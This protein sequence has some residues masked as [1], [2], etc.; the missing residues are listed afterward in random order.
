MNAAGFLKFNFAD[1]AKIF[2]FPRID[3]SSEGAK[4]GWLVRLRW[5]ALTMLFLL[6][7]PGFYFGILDRG[8]MVIYIGVV[9][10][11]FVFNFLTQLIF[12][13]P[14]RNFGPL[15]ICLQM[16][17]DLIALTILLGVSG[18]FGNPF[19]GVF[20]LNAALGGVLIRGRLAWPFILLCH[21]LLSLLQ[22]QYGETHLEKQGS[23]LVGYVIVS[24]VILFAVWVVM[25]SLGAS[26]ENHFESLTHARVQSEKQDRL[27]ALG[28]LAAGFSHEFAS[29]LNA[30]RLRLDRLER[31]LREAQVSPAV[32]ENLSEALVSIQAC[33]SVVHSMNSS[34]LDVRDYA[35]KCI[36]MKEFLQDVTDSW[37]ELHPQAHLL[38][39]TSSAVDLVASPVNLAQ[40]IINLLDN[41]LEA[42]AD[43]KILLSLS[44]ESGWVSL[45][46]EDEGPGF[47]PSVLGKKGEPFVTTKA[48]GT[49]LG[50]Y[51][52]DIFVQ[53]M[54]GR[55]LI[56]NKQPG[57]T[58]S[59]TWPLV[60]S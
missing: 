13:G 20:L 53:S 16:A 51:V 3:G 55:L 21:S 39:N 59:L 46:V 1:G 43:G 52:S 35:L 12:V 32:L 34:Q 36:N 10:L 45:K 23:T 26:L 37:K 15:F 50:L 7:G 17:A 22:I 41:A 19:V 42:R 25:R 4:I 38:V 18:S 8:N 33:E 44:V 60:G 47:A 9:A 30:A 49:G 28:A 5:A 40:V 31:G 6:A 24:H 14:R 56:E 2:T 11:M 48:E 54:G 29:P 57:A 58:V 27:R